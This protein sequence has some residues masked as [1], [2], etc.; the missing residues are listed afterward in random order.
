M[1][2][3]FTPDLRAKVDWFPGSV[4]PCGTDSAITD[5]QGGGEDVAAVTVDGRFPTRQGRVPRW[6]RHGDAA[7]VGQGNYQVAPY[8]RK[9]PQTGKDTVKRIKRMNQQVRAHGVMEKVMLVTSISPTVRHGR[10]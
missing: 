3:R 9:G 8:C 2:R 1:A 7:V 4:P 5:A 6:P 10:A